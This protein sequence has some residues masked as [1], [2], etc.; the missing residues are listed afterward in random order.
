MQ[1]MAWLPGKCVAMLASRASWKRR[2]APGPLPRQLPTRPAPACEGGK[3]STWMI[4]DSNS[5]SIRR[6]MSSAD[7]D[8][9]HLEQ[10][11]QQQEILIHVPLL[12]VPARCSG[13]VVC[14]VATQQCC[15]T[16]LCCTTQHTTLQEHLADLLIAEPT[17]AAP[18]GMDVNCSC[19]VSM[20]H[21]LPVRYMHPCAPSPQ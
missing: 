4:R 18:T 7:V 13:G 17:S 16:M 14:C 10:Q 12:L 11:Q 8:V 9:R 20:N 3:I 19:C 5:N 15:I 21:A 6:N 2:A 1:L